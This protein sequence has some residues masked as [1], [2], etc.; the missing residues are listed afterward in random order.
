MLSD[1][2][3]LYIIWGISI[4]TVIILRFLFSC[5]CQVVKYFSQIV[6]KDEE[7][8]E[9]R[10]IPYR[11]KWV[12]HSPQIKRSILFKKK[13]LG[14]KAISIKHLS[15]ETQ[16]K[17]T[18]AL[19][20]YKKRIIWFY[21]HNSVCK[22]EIVSYGPYFETLNNELE[23]AIKDTKTEYEEKLLLENVEHSCDLLKQLCCSLDALVESNNKKNLYKQQLVEKECCS[24]HE[25]DFDVTKELTLLLGGTVTEL[26][27]EPLTDKTEIYSEEKKQ[28]S[29]KGNC[30]SMV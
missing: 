7:L 1:G 3:I 20:P 12:L 26:K 16:R 22:Q 18:D 29:K 4:V 13:Y 19:H 11:L 24:E 14:T 5:I 25:N 9:W 2:T 30:V 23:R 27:S 10:F 15:P 6:E 17:I 21:E 8:S 28:E